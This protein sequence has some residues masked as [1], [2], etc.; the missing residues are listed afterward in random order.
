L[1]KLI[2]NKRRYLVNLGLYSSLALP[3][4]VSRTTICICFTALLHRVTSLLDGTSSVSLTIKPR[5]YGRS[6]GVSY[7]IVQHFPSCVRAAAVG[8]ACSCLGMAVPAG[9]ADAS[10]GGIRAMENCVVGVNW[11]QDLG[12]GTML[13]DTFSTSPTIKSRWYGR[14]EGVSYTI[15]QHSLFIIFFNKTRTILFS[16]K[17]RRTALHYIKKIKTGV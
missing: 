1:K 9:L 4:L 7:T 11:I 15:V 12:F 2:F 3:G 8:A 17:C 14:G 5:W 6:E 10:D 13:D 16:Q